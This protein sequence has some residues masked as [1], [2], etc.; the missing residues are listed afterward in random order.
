MWP[1]HFEE[2]C[3]SR[4]VCYLV[5]CKNQ[6]EE[7]DLTNFINR[8]VQ[9]TSDDSERFRTYCYCAFG[10][11]GLFFLAILLMHVTNESVRISVF[12][13]FVVLWLSL[14]LLAFADV[15][16]L[17][18]TSVKVFQMSRSTNL[19]DHSWFEEHKDRFFTVL[20]MFIIMCIAWPIKLFTVASY[21]D[22]EAKIVSDVIVFLS[23][24][25]LFAIIGLKKHIRDRISSRYGILNDD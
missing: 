3:L 16:F 10:L 1:H 22:Y 25:L 2:S 5:E 20:Q 13:A 19:S 15:V 9:V 23:A 24:I 21:K 18:L 14:F 8:K 17:M 4:P 6:S 7:S 12:Y 11:L